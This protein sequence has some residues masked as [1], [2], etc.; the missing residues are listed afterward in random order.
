[1]NEKNKKTEANLV[2]LDDHDPYLFMTR[3][4][5]ETMLLNERGV[6]PSPYESRNDKKNIWYLDNGARNHITCNLS[7]FT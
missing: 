7:F 1:M 4:L 5:Y 3:T 6:I 2:E